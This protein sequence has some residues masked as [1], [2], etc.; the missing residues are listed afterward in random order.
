MDEL[1]AQLSLPKS[2]SFIFS[3]SDQN[4]KYTRLNK[5]RRRT[6]SF[7]ILGTGCSFR[8]QLNDYFLTEILP[9]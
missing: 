2:K 5:P 4:S 1:H 3:N 7:V 6:C 9:F 8:L